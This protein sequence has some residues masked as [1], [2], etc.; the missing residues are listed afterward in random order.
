MRWWKGEGGSGSLSLMFDARYVD[1]FSLFSYWLDVPFSS[2]YRV[3]EREIV[4][5][6]GGGGEGRRRQDEEA[7]G[8]SEVVNGM[9]LQE[10]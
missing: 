7:Y 3:C 1:S 10:V 4:A 2:A 8:L 5:G 6:A 9:A